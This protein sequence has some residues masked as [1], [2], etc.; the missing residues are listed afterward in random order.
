MGGDLG[1]TTQAGISYLS[2]DADLILNQATQIIPGQR[3]LGQGSSQQISQ[4][5]SLVREFGYFGQIEGNYK[6]QFVGTLGYRIDKST[7]NGDPNKFYGFP[8]ASLAINL[9]NFDG[10]QSGTIDQFKIR[11]AYGETGSS[12][13]FGSIFTSLNQTSIG[14]RR[15]KY[16]IYKR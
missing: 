14:G 3:A 7:L 8:K 9:Q 11:A 5:Q 4:T 2:R 13:G 1:L 6:D 12:A 16:I 15:F 10:W